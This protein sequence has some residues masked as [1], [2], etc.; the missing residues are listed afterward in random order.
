MEIC[1][2]DSSDEVP[3]NRVE[4]HNVSALIAVEREKGCR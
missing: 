2:F 4:R 3:L 1:R